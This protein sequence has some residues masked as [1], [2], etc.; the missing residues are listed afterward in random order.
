MQLIQ[1]VK[2]GSFFGVLVNFFNLSVFQGAGMLLQFLA[3]PLITRKYGIEVFGETVVATSFAVFMGGVTN[4]GTHQTAIKEVATSV[5]NKPFLS[6]LFY[7]VL[8]F[9]AYASLLVIP[10][11]AIMYFLYPSMPLWLWVSLLPLVIAE[12][13]N[14]MYF[15]IGV[16]KIEWISW[17]NLLVK[18]ISLVALW[19]LPLQTNIAASVNIIMGLPVLIYYTVLSIVIVKKES[20]HFNKPNNHDLLL[21]AKQN[22]YIMFNGVA[23][24]LQQSIFL[25]AVAGFVPP[26][27]LGAYGVVDK[28]L[29]AVRQLVSSFSNALYPR[30]AQ[31]YAVS[32]SNWFGF[33]AQVNKGYLVVFGVAAMVIYVAAPQIVWLLTG[34]VNTPQAIQT[35][36]FIQLFAA[37]PLVLAL[38]ANNVL[39]LLLEHKYVA[40]F[41]ISVFILVATA[42]L[43]CL[44]I[45]WGN[46]WVLGWYPLAIE[47]VCLGIYT[48]YIK[49]KAK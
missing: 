32:S 16:Q 37:A 24:A 44:L 17:G 20:L 7:K 1:R 45:F 49:Q 28:L 23:V 3:I 43:S 14:P 9:R 6:A 47:T 21:L 11:I 30:A 25:F 4:Y 42:L 18:L 48:Y 33:K 26:Q 31:L 5:T 40:L 13:V 35:K 36:G 34:A 41:Y 27:T 46:A 38:N 12:V 22:F 2:S 39:T 19:V 29:G 15:L 8:F 10:A